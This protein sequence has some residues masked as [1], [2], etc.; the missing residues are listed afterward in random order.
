MI[1]FLLLSLFI[2]LH[3]YGIEAIN[4]TIT[5]L[6]FDAKS[7]KTLSKDGIPVPLVAH[8]RDSQRKRLP[9][10]HRPGYGGLHRRP[11]AGCA[12][13]V[14]LLPRGRPL[15]HPTAEQRGLDPRL[16]RLAGQVPQARPRLAPLKL[17]K[18]VIAPLRDESGRDNK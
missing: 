8:P 1:K 2:T 3:L 13:A 11:G 14:S 9:R 16:L 4:G 17:T 5:I 7:I 10:A 18:T 12:L 6:E 15:G